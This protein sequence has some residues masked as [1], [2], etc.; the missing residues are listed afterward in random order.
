VSKTVSSCE[1]TT[2]MGYSDVTYRKNKAEKKGKGL[3]EEEDEEEDRRRR[4]RKEEKKGERR[5][6]TTTT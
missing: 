6:T 3:A 4:R 1:R 2:C 5:G